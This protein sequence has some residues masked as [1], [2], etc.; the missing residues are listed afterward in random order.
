[1]LEQ[2]QH[3]VQHANPYVV[4]ALTQVHGVYVNVY[5]KDEPDEYDEGRDTYISNPYKFN[6]EPIYSKI[7]LFLY[8]PIQFNYDSG[9]TSF[10]SYMKDIYILTCD[11]RFQF[12]E[13]QK[14]EVFYRKRDKEPQRV[15]QSFEVKEL[16]NAYNQWSIRKI[17]L[18]PFN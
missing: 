18:Q 11:K 10:D 15:F 12:Y 16:S 13:K 6:D 4:R 14:F 7:K 3:A 5:N 9:D 1:M 17:F 8:D 2:I